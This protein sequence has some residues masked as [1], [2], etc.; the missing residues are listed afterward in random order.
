MQIILS[1]SPSSEQL[2]DLKLNSVMASSLINFSAAAQ[3]LFHYMKVNIN[4][5]ETFRGRHTQN[6]LLR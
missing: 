2:I 6:A 4:Q 5:L 1:Y 3:V